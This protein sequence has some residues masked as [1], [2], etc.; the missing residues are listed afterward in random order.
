[1]N[2]GRQSAARPALQL[3]AIGRDAGSVLVDANDGRIN[4]LHSRIMVSG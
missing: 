4:H 1:M 2:L 3:L